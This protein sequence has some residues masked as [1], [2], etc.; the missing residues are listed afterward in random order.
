MSSYMCVLCVY[1]LSNKED[2]SGDSEVVISMNEEETKNRLLLS[3]PGA[4]H[5]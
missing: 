3:P 5:E 2:V 4:D 1:V